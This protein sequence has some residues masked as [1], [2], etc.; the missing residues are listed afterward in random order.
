MEGLG[1]V[2]ES[3]EDAR[4]CLFRSHVAVSRAPSADVAQS[5][6]ETGCVLNIAATS[7]M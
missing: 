4:E 3:E 7:S 5:K 6:R 2:K 1:S